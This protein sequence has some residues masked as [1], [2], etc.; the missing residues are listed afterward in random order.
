[1][2]CRAIAVPVPNI[3]NG[4]YGR[5]VGYAVEQIVLDDATVAISATHVRRVSAKP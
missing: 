4:F 2:K 5:H 3:T 1:M